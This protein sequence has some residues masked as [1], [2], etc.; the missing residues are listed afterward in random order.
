MSLFTPRANT[1]GRLA[2]LALLAAPIVAVLF[3]LLYARTPFYTNQAFPIQQPVQF[4]HRHHVADDGIDCRYCHDTVMTSWT[5]GFP[6]TER[7]MGCHSQIW[8]ESPLLDVVRRSYFQGWPIRWKR[9]HRLPD[10]VYFDH[11]I[12]VNKGIGCL[13][14][15]GR[16]DQ[17]PNLEQ[18]APLS[19]GWCIKCHREPN[20]QLRPM[21]EI[22]NLR[23][24][25]PDD[26]SAFE[27]LAKLYDLHPRTSC[28]TCH[29]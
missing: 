3:A 25:P 22:T 10:F 7:C 27:A 5:A 4:D 8:N 23:W 19:M 24:T 14:C 20:S 1:L 6:P 18:A 26:P 29:R 17:M 16:V 21:A 15:H 12:H 9:V 13:S 11:S 28:T 2:L